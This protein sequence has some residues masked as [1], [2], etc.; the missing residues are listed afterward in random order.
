MKS[1]WQHAS[2][3]TVTQA[4]HREESCDMGFARGIGEHKLRCDF[5]AREPADYE[6]ENLKLK[7]PKFW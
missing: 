1:F 2:L 6:R 3:V 4:E 5:A 7:R